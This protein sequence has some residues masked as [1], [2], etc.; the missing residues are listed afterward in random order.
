MRVEKKLDQ[1]ERCHRSLHILPKA[2]RRGVFFF[3]F[4]KD[5][6]SIKSPFTFH[7]F[8]DI[9]FPFLP[10]FQD[11]RYFFLEMVLLFSDE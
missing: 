3:L 7:P 5:S 4:C 10:Y 2:A 9:G 1:Q 11:Q 8:Q 6:V